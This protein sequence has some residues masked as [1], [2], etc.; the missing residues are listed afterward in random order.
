MYLPNER[1]HNYEINPYLQSQ[2]ASSCIP[3]V[4]AIKPN[5]VKRFSIVHQCS[6]LSLRLLL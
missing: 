1:D 5:A 3:L 6:I 2:M 4:H